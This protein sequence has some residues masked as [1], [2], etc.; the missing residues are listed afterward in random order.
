MKGI[1]FNLLEETVAA[2]YGAAAWDEL[3]AA[4]GTD[5]AYTSLGSY[6]DSQMQDLV[7]AA[8]AKLGKSPAEVLRWFG[9]AAM[10]LLAHRYPK[11]FQGLTS[12]RAFLLSVNSIIHPEVRKVYPGAIVPTFDFRDAEDGSL[13]MGYRSPRRLCALAQG[14]T[15]GA[16]AHFHE[17]I[18]FTHLKCMHKGDDSCLCH[19]RFGS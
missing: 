7:L 11:Y 5:G 4:T 14:F 9:K 18:A 15:E 16:A 12:T 2:E 17:S 1:V 8:S 10:P 13:L 19:I 3:L 6:A